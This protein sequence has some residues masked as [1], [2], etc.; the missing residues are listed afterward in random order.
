MT[1]R[2]APP[3]V[4]AAGT[5]AA[6]LLLLAGAAA[7][8]AAPVFVRLGE[9]GPLAAGFW[10]VALALPLFALVCFRPRERP[11]P[12][13]GAGRL[14]RRN[15]VLLA[16]GGVF[17]GL[18][19]AFWNTSITLTTAANATLLAN[20][21]P[22][23]VVLA[24]FLLFGERAGARL[25]LGLG[26][27]LGGAVLL[28][29]G[30]ADPDPAR[31]RG[32]AFA[33]AAAVFYT[34]YLLTVKRVRATASTAVVM[35]GGGLAAALVLLPAALLAGER[36]L[37]AT[38]A[39]WAPLLAL[40]L[41]CQVGGQA[42]IA[43]ALRGLPAGFASV[44]LLVQPVAAALLGFLVFG[45]TLTGWQALGAAIVLGGVLTA[46]RAGPAAAP[47]AARRRAS[48]AGKTC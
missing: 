17:Y 42:A 16:G 32:D 48:L 40:A 24:G 38:A 44:G 2:A 8:G 46:T 19:L 23:F 34:A 41:V 22:V 26:L 47:P 21:A 6:V 4:P 3:A 9:T 33:V 37:P 14:T 29:G 1:L 7:T 11:A 13:A 43:G 27:A 10:R 20:L 35:L 30:A 5:R 36:V 28:V 39:G 12:P 15:L 45:E 18:D 25:C 31:L